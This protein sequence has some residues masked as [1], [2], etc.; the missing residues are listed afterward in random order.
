MKREKFLQAIIEEIDSFD[1]EDM[2]EL[3]NTY[4]DEQ[5]YID[6]RIHKN[7]DSFF[8]DNFSGIIDAVRAVSYGE[9]RYAD[10]YVKFNGYGNLESFSYITDADLCDH[11]TT[12]AEHVADNFH[13]Y[14][15]IFAL[16][17]TDEEADEDDNTNLEP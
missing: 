3:N 12:I 13:K 5:N 17:D 15:H 4:C 10:K 14:D 7:D 8:E 11:V 16:E 6:D 2:A 1:S 9:Y